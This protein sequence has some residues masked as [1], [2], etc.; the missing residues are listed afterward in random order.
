MNLLGADV[1]GT[2]VAGSDGA[3]PKLTV[4]EIKTI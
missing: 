1:V 3:N 2:L 4:K